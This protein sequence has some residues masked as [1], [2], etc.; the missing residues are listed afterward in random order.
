MASTYPRR[1]SIPN[2]T[3]MRGQ[4]TAVLSDAD[5]TLTVSALTKAIRD[6]LEAAFTDVT[7]EGEI[8]NFIDHRSGHRYWT[9]KDAASQISCVFWKSRTLSFPMRDGM[10]VVCRGRLTVYPPRGNYQLDVFQVRPSGVGDLQKVYEERYERL[11]A[12]GLFEESR[13]RPIPKFPQTIGIVTSENGAALHDILTTIERRY[14]VVHVLVRPCAVQGVGAE[15]EIARAIQEFNLITPPPM[16]RSGIGGG[17]GVVQS[18]LAEPLGTPPPS[19]LLL[20]RRG[21]RPDVLIVGRGGG[22]LE[23]LWCFNEEA[24]ARAIYAS[25]IPVISAVG[26]EVD[27][28]IADFVADLRA[29]TPTA[30]AELATPNSEELLSAIRIGRIG[31]IRR[32][33][34]MI[35]QHRYAVDAA[36]DKR[37]LV[38]ALSNTLLHLRG[39]LNS[40]I[41]GASRAVIH[42]L[43]RKRLRFERD[44]AKLAAM[45]PDRVLDRGFTALE[46]PEGEIIPRLA[47]LLERGEKNG[48]LI[49]ADGRITVRF[50]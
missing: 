34:Q 18:E 9:L 11:R 37:S 16:E 41:L 20:Q 14:P 48:I 50:D 24:V 13:K 6:T 29:P 22:S 7:V 26:H 38:M 43:E 12:E 4:Q 8:S 25:K 46:S 31:L 5:A 49:F 27:F 17:W 40:E 36:S 3:P 44:A 10:K 30:A 1:S 45:N 21:S 15:L 28:T 19:P 42:S 33:R 32:M 23:D 2:L 47:Q 39:Q 35:V